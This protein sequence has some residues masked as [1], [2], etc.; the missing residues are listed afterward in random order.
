MQ[1]TGSVIQFSPS[2]LNHFL[3]C[4]H[5]IRLEMRREGSVERV[6]D[7]HAELLAAKGLEHERAWLR[8]FTDAGRRLVEIEHGGRER[9]WTRDA[10]RTLAAMRDGADVIYQG[11]LVAHGESGEIWRGVSDFLVRTDT[12]SPRFGAWSYEAWDTKLARR[13]RP[14]HILQLCFYSGQLGSLQG[15]DPAY[16]HLVL[17][18]GETRSFRY[19][20]FEAYYRAVRRTFIHATSRDGF[21]YPYPVSHCRLCEHAPSCAARRKA[22]DHLSLV[23]GI[24]RD[25]VDRLNEAGVQTVGE[26]ARFGDGREPG[27]GGPA[28]E[29][30]RHQAA[31]QAHYRVSGRHKYDLLPAD[32]HSGF[33]LLPE[34]SPGDIFF[35]MEGDPY[36][37]PAR[38][39]EY[40][41]GFVTVGEASSF[42]H[43]MALDR[44]EEKRAF[45]R[46]IDFVHERLRSW[47]DLHVY[48]YASYEITA[49]KRLMSEYATRE[50]ELDDLLRKE[51][52]VDLYQVVRQSM[53]I[54][55][56]G[57]SIKQV[58]TFFMPGAGQGQVADGGDSIL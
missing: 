37:D 54:S 39:L 50:D 4:A 9:D 14:Y 30:L 13:D 33:R 24:R 23:A 34:P 45:E 16:M 5:L 3:E 57:Y 55:H 51:V 29:R 49:L 38:G 44:A 21:T 53:R 2:D 43:F 15:V 46:F 48:H 56:P 22:D 20:D 28:L 6:R 1:R 32:E 17:G 42:R 7:P 41:F 58:R 8:R 27:I 31:L 40:L 52:F 18:T 47:P 19:T 12:A 26:L 35:D 10:E 36:F 11:V 25:Q